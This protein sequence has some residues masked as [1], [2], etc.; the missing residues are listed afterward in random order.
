RRHTRSDRDWSSDVCSSDL[1]N[2]RIATAQKEG[3]NLKIVWKGNI[4]DAD[5]WAIPKGTPKRDEAYKYIKF[6]SQPENQKVFSSEI[7]Y[8][9][10]RKSVVQMLD[11]K[12]VADLPTAPANLKD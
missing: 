7:T 9:P 3:K 5:H 11:P 4:Y 8:G 10:D 2:G 12:S 1:Y 6:A